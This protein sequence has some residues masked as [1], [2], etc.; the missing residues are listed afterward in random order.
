MPTPEQV[1]FVKKQPFLN[2]WLGDRRPLLG[3]EIAN[4]VYK[5]E[6]NTLGEALIT[7]FSQVVK[8]KEVRQF[9]L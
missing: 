8:S 5:A 3:I 7:G 6:R 9:M 4:L 2:G 1:D